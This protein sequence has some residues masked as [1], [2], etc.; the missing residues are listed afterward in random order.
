[1][2]S[3][4]SPKC[5]W[6]RPCQMCQFVKIKTMSA[7]NLTFRQVDDDNQSRAFLLEQI[8]YPA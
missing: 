5:W 3:L 8:Q 6:C 2:S 7:K 4:M 1:M